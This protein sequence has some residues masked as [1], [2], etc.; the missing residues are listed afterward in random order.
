MLPF[1]PSPAAERADPVI[2]RLFKIDAET[3]L[4]RRL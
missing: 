4:H 3:V 2:Q 1:V